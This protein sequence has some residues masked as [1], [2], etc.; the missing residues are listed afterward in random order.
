[1]VVALD[2]PPDGFRT[3]VGRVLWRRFLAADGFDG[4]VTPTAARRSLGQR[5]VIARVAEFAQLAGDLARFEQQAV[6]SKVVLGRLGVG[7]RS[8]RQF[9]VARE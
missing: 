8:S 9:S 4:A 6:G 5:E 7:P 2:T 3:C 1:V